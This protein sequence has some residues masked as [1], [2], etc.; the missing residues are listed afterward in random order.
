MLKKINNKIK[1]MMLWL[2]M[3]GASFYL[4]FCETDSFLKYF[5]IPFKDLLNILVLSIVVY[6]FVEYKND[7]RSRKQSLDHLIKKV[8]SRLEDPRMYKIS[9]DSDVNHI[10][11]IQKSIN[12]ELNIIKGCAVDFCFEEE[13]NYCQETFKEYWYFISEHLNEIDYLSKSE[14]K[15]LNDIV[16]II[17]R[18]EVV[19]VNL[20]K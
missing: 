11:I 18:L 13:A 19:T 4:H 9:Q 7:E 20:H 2:I 15:L 12:N 6:I 14:T 10:R 5:Y 8:I 16:N 3:V 1:L 17:W